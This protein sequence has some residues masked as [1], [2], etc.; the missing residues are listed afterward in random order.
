MPKHTTEGLPEI[1]IIK[2][3]LAL[4]VKKNSSALKEMD[5]WAIA[6]YITAQQ[7]ALLDKAKN[8]MPEV[9]AWSE[10]DADSVES[11]SARAFN[12]ARREALDVLAALRSEIK[13]HHE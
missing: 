4:R 12:S 7:L 10:K 11:N 1:R 3:L 8:R 6:D 5:A 9:R 2:D 13:G